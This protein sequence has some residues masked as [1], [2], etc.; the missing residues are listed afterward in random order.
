VERRT[1][2]DVVRVGGASGLFYVLNGIDAAR[3]GTAMSKRTQP[4]Q[5]PGW[6]A[7]PNYVIGFDI[8][9]ATVAVT[10]AGQT[11]AESDKARCMY[12]LGHAPAYYFPISALKMEFLTRTEHETFCPYKGVAAYWTV[13]V[14]GEVA[15]NAIWAYPNAY[16]EVPLLKDYAGFYWGRMERWTEDGRAVTGP[17]EIPGRVDTT[18]QLKAAFPQLNAEWLKEKNHCSAYEFS[19]ESDQ[20]VWWKDANGRE[21]QESIRDRVLKLTTLRGDGDA[22]PYG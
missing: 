2:T 10:F 15:E 5:S 1:S 11:I 4:P 16:A 13:E 19:C 3:M 8:I 9:P 12:E 14:D 21:W 22:T 20:V 7:N 18:N 6:A 17:R